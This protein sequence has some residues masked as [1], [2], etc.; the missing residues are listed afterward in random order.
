VGDVFGAE[1]VAFAFLEPFLTNIVAA[2][3][4]FQTA[5]DATETGTSP[6]GGDNVR[7]FDNDRHCQRQFSEEYRIISSQLSAFQIA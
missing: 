7:I 6:R 1:G 2:D 3:G 4:K 5:E